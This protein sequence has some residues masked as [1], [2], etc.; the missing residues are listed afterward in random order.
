M[1]RTTPFLL[2]YLF[3]ITYNYGQ[4]LVPN[5]GFENFDTCAPGYII[6]TSASNFPGVQNWMSACISM[7]PIFSVCSSNAPNTNLCGYHTAH[8][9]NAFAG[10]NIC[11]D[12]PVVYF[13]GPLCRNFRSY[14]QVQLISPLKKDTQYCVEFFVENGILNF[15]ENSFLCAANIGAYLSTERPRNYNVGGVN[16]L[17]RGIQ[18]QIENASTNYICDTL[19]WQSING[20]YKAQGGEQWLTIG[21][22]YNDTET[23]FNPAFTPDSTSIDSSA[24]ILIDDVSVTPITFPQASKDTL[25][26]DTSQLTETQNAQPGGNYYRWGNGATGQSIIIH[27]PGTY[28]YNTDFGCGPVVDSIHIH[29]QPPLSGHL[30]ADTN[31]CASNLPLYLA[32]DSGFTHY[33]W[34]TGDTTYI[35]AISDSGN[36]QVQAVYACGYFYDTVHVSVYPQPALPP[37][38]DTGICVNTGTYVAVVPGTNI[39]YYTN[40]TDSAGNLMPPPYYHYQCRQ[41]YFLCSPANKWLLKRPKY[42]ARA[43]YCCAGTKCCK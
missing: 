13:Q 31:G 11:F 32:I 23:V 24:I 33:T 8:S 27:Q 41:L 28:W 2:F 16:T 34:N 1:K 7:P 21:N 10:V 3:I 43:G 4:N 20:I 35:I 22:F 40:L 39:H 36:Y 15:R 25:L 5:P 38:I 37:A 26:C 14:I 6:D 12:D 19:H 18:P 42:G 29:F 30:P 9:G 17:L